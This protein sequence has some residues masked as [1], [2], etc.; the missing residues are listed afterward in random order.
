MIITIIRIITFPSHVTQNLSPVPEFQR[1]ELRL[2]DAAD[3]Q[4]LQ[5]AHLVAREP[6]L[7]RRNIQHVVVIHVRLAQI[8]KLPRKIQPAVA[9][10]FIDEIHVLGVDLLKAEIDGGV[11]TDDELIGFFFVFVEFRVDKFLHLGAD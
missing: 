7:L 4:E 11:I 2:S 10:D 3:V 6:L 1:N 5:E 8:E 9:V